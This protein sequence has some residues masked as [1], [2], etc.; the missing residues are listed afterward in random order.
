MGRVETRMY[1]R[2]AARAKTMRRL[3]LLV[4]LG[5]AVLIAWGRLDDGFIAEHLSLPTPT[6]V[7]PDFNQTV[8]SRE[9]TLQADT[10][11]AIQ[12]GVFSTQEAALEKADAYTQRG[13]P[14]TVIQ[15]G[16][17]WRVF[18]ACYST[19]DAASSV[20][21][22][23]ETVQK[24]DT[25]LYAWKCPEV[26][27]RLTGKAGQLDTVEAGF[28]LLTST[29]AALR[30]AA[31]DLD[32]GQLT[33]EEALVSVTALDSAVKLWEE[34]VRSRFGKVIPELVQ[35]MLH[36]TSGCRERFVR[37]QDAQEATTLSASL[38]AEAMGMYDDMISWRNALLAK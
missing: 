24:V 31:T 27:L 16:E 25:Y 26:R 35:E 8:E 30:D 34:T 37:L 38:K 1:K 10:W 36:I 9:V 13:A 17:K 23:L 33:T 20:R 15:D 22:R 14:G 12:T 2:R 4:L 6:P 19:E 21:R 7:T 29:A 11:Y 5:A 3:L 18:I 32:A 28:T